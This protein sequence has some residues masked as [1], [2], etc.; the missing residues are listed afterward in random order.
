MWDDMRHTAG[1]G[2]DFFAQNLTNQELE[3]PQHASKMKV[4]PDKHVGAR[5][6]HART[7]LHEKRNTLAREALY[8]CTTRV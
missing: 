8:T 6:K 5:R 2:L 3:Q 1:P 7:R 4:A